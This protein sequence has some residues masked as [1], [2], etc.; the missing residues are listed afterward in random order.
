METTSVSRFLGTVD[1]REQQTLRWGFMR[2]LFPRFAEEVELG[3][4]MKRLMSGG[5][6]SVLRLE[7]HLEQT[8]T[9]ST[10]VFDVYAQ[11][12]CESE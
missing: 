11:A 9:Y 5:R 10:H 3:R 7:P 4:Y 2:A 8:G 6:Y 1:A 12:G